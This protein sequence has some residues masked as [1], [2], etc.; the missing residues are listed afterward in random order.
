MKAL[1][2]N[3]KQKKANQQSITPRETSKQPSGFGYICNQ[4]ANQNKFKKAVKVC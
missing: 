3:L 1:S 4:K 2:N